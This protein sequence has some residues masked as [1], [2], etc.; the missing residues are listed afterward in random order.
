[1]ELPSLEILCMGISFTLFH[2]C[3][4]KH[5]HKR[6]FSSSPLIACNV[7]QNWGICPTLARPTF[8]SECN[9]ESTLA[10]GHLKWWLCYRSGFDGFSTDECI[11]AHFRKRHG[12]KVTYD[13]VHDSKVK[14]KEKRWKVAMGKLHW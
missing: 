7:L 3:T 10:G 6:T 4:Y 13:L 11:N 9:Q 8:S 2:K 14:F 1:M 5:T 12:R